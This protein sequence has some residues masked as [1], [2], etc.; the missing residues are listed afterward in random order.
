MKRTGKNNQ[1]NK[2]NRRKV[3]VGTPK[4][5]PVAAEAPP[6]KPAPKKATV[7]KAAGKKQATLKPTAVTP[8]AKADPA[9]KVDVGTLLQDPA[10]NKLLAMITNQPGLFTQVANSAAAVA[11]T[12]AASNNDDSVSETSVVEVVAV[13]SKKVPKT[14]RAGTA[15][16]IKQEKQACRE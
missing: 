6:K 12:S 10:V 8:V 14:T 3:L 15:V 11:D 5:V 9:D 16:A 2:K 7:K 1:S 13:T 4:Q